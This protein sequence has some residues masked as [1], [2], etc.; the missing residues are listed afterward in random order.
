MCWTG[1]ERNN[2]RARAT[3]A[4]A[5]AA[6]RIKKQ[7]S[8]TSSNIEETAALKTEN[9]IR[10]LDVDTTSNDVKVCRYF[11]TVLKDAIKET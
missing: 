5:A 8:K 11:W 4:A 1:N 10:R 3:A 6:T 7:T 2:D 9:C